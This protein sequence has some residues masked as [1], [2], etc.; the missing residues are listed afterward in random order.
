MTQNEI[1]AANSVVL[2]ELN[3]QGQPIFEWPFTFA[4][5]RAYLDQLERHAGL[6]V[7]RVDQ[8]RG[9]LADAEGRSGSA[10]NRALRELADALDADAAQSMDGDK[11]RK[12]QE[13]IR[14]L[15]G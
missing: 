8:V 13:A 7:S 10:Q 1:D 4:L 9:A 5:A 12:L 14:G 2:N 6:S 3:S 15:A 11:V